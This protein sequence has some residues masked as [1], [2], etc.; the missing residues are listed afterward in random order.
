MRKNKDFDGVFQKLGDD[1]N[2]ESFVMVCNKCYKPDNKCY[3]E[4]FGITE[5]KT[6]DGFDDSYDEGDLNLSKPYFNTG[7]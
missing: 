1:P 5:T 7:C 4:S 6:E 2:E 3:C